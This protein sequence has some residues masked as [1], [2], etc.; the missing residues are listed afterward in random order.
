MGHSKRAEEFADWL[1]RFITGRIYVGHLGEG[2]RLPSVRQLVELR[3]EDHRVVMAA[4]RLLEEEGVV[5][6]RKGSGVYLRAVTGAAERSG[7]ARWLTDVLLE[8]WRRGLT[9]AQV[10]ASLSRLTSR[11]VRVACVETTVDHMVALSAGI[12]EDFGY[13]VRQVQLADGGD[14]AKGADVVVCTPFV[15]SEARS[16]AEGLGLPC[17]VVRINPALAVE[18]DRRLK[19]G[20]VTAVIADP[21][22]GE[23]MERYFEGSSNEGRVTR[24]VLAEDVASLSEVEDGE[25]VVLATRAARRALG[26][27]DYHIVPSPPG[28]V[29]PDSARELIEV[30]TRIARERDGEAG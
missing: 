26:E 9:P 22:Y 24:V 12:E 20:D 11:E 25:R 7:D 16:L 30:V 21:A 6:V 5:D 17:V 2:D 23:R 28:Y 19:A 4:Y 15:E 27:A 18:I 13:E 3:E 14:A 1:R 29:G 10:T 8:G